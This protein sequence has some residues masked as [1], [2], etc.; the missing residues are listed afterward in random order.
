M[1]PLPIAILLFGLVAAWLIGLTIMM[2]W[3]FFGGLM[4]RS[5][6]ADRE[7]TRYTLESEGDRW[8]VISDDG[9][10]DEYPTKEQALLHLGRSIREDDV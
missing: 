4:S 9:A 7:W 3:V 6:R 10:A 5:P 1:M 2:L 8:W